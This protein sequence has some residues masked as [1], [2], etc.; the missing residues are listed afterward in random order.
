MQGIQGIP[1][2]QVSFAANPDGTTTVTVGSSSFTTGAAEVRDLEYNPVNGRLWITTK[3]G[4]EEEVYLPLP[5]VMPTFTA[6]Q[7]NAGNTLFSA[8]V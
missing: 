6:I 1:G 2:T 3:D 7:D 4:N 8:V 5:S